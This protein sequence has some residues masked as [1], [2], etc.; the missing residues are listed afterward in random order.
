[1]GG[2]WEGIEGRGWNVPAAIVAHMSGNR[3]SYERVRFIGP[4][5]LLGRAFSI[6]ATGCGDST[7]RLGESWEK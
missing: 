3:N 1:M 7:F 4:W 5:L 6:V 2:E